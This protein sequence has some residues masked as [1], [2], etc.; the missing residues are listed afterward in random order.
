MQTYEQYLET[1]KAYRFH[2]LDRETW[3]LWQ[4]HHH[5]HFKPSESVAP[6]DDRSSS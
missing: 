4:V 5:G 3:Q 6:P 2:P 1:M